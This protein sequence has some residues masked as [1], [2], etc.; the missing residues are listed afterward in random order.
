MVNKLTLS[1][2]NDIDFIEETLSPIA[3]VDDFTRNLLK[4]NKIVQKEGLAQPVTSCINR[5]DYMLDKCSKSSNF[6][7]RQVEVNAIA[8]SMSAHSCSAQ[9][10]HEHLLAKY[11][12]APQSGLKF[13]ENSSLSLVAQGL[14]DAFEAYGSESAY[15]LLVAEERSLN[16]SDQFL[17]EL[18]VRK[19]RPGIRFVRRS[20]ASL[21]ELIKLGPNK[22]L[23]LEDNKECGLV[24]FRYCYDPTQYN[25]REAWDVRLMLERSKAIK[26]P[27]INFHLAGAKKFQ[28]VLNSHQQLERYLESSAAQS[29]SEV[30]AKI[31]SIEADNANGREG[32]ELGI[33]GSKNLVLKPQR[34]GGG[35]NIFGQDIKPFLERIVDSEERTQYI[36]MEYINSPREKNWLLLPDDSNDASRLSKSD[37]LVSELGI[38]GSILAEG[39]TVRSNRAAGYL[40]R[41]KRFGVNEGGVATGYAGISSLVL[42]PSDTVKSELSAPDG[43]QF[44]DCC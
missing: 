33:S 20:F 13:P 21:P 43:S 16:F 34:E 12:V 7:V 40:V 26:C 5:A 42:L 6:R 37:L 28:Q 23:L 36:I 29:L 35:H 8:S 18:E 41:S 27:S 1:I 14:V 38:F 11:R 10:L 31:W 39:T 15:I 24:Y 30:F 9:A 32:F 25:F 17:I 2:A 22:E 3:Q 4:L 44:F 19:L